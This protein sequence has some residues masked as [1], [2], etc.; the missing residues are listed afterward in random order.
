MTASVIKIISSFQK[1]TQSVVTRVMKSSQNNAVNDSHKYLFPDLK[2]NAV[3]PCQHK[4]LS[5]SVKCQCCEFTGL[6]KRQYTIINNFSNGY[7]KA[8]L[9]SKNLKFLNMVPELYLIAIQQQ[10]YQFLQQRMGKRPVKQS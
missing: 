2:N 1:D 8:F 4:R 5:R 9:T 10:Q 7:A 6:G 3:Q